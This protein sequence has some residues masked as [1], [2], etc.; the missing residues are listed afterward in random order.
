MA[1]NVQ[2]L[3]QRTA[4]ALLTACAHEQPG[5]PPAPTAV[6]LPSAV[7]PSGFKVPPSA[8]LAER[9]R[10]IDRELARRNLNEFGDPKSMTYAE[11]APLSV[12]K[13]TDRYDYVLQHRRYIGVACTRAPGEPEW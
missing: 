13:G 7:Q 2:V 10:C 3:L 9:N 12:I 11:G 1:I 8:Y 6:S 5:T 4:L